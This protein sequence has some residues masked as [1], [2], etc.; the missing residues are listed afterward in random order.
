[1]IAGQ[2]ML[3]VAVIGAGITGLTLAYELAQRGARVEVYEAGAQIGGELATVNVNGEPV[4]RFY[5]HLFL[6]DRHI[7]DLMGQL[8]IADRLRWGSPRMAYFADGQLYPFTSPIDLLR[9]SAIPLADRIRMGLATLRLQRIREYAQFEDLRAGDVLPGLT[10]Q[11]A[12]DTVWRPLLEAKFGEEWPTVSMAWFWGRVNVRFRSRD[13]L[14]MRELLGYIDG[15]FLSI[16]RELGRRAEELGA[17]IHLNSPVDRIIHSAGRI[18]GLSVGGAKVAADAVIGTVGLPILRRLLPDHD[19]VIRMPAIKY[20][21]ALV[22]LLQLKARLSKYYWTNVADRQ[23]PFPGLIEHTN[24]VDPERYGGAHLL[25]VSNYL[26]PGHDYFNMTDS[27]LLDEYAPAIKS[28]FP[29]FQASL[30]DSLWVSGDRVAQPVIAAGYQRQMPGFATALKGFFI[31][32]T[33]QIYPEDRG[34]NYNVRIARQCA[35][36]VIEP[37]AGGGLASRPAGAD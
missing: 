11:R 25:Y 32:N 28:V 14:G 36:L 27:E 9:F 35:A 2:P 29:A 3:K 23:V 31:C 17:T 22:M 16:T 7:Q 20:R 5:H 15:S 26:D 24:F 37:A 10:G 19:D 12:F 13:R 4:E 6:G 30:I 1:M 34:T 21:G 8:G 18:E 33:S